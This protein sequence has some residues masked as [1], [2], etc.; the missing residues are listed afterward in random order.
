MSQGQLGLAGQAQAFGQAG[1]TFDRNYGVYQD[2]RDTA[3]NQQMG[4]AQLGQNSATNYGNQ[5]GGYY[6]GQGNANGAAAIQQGNAWS[7]A[8][9]GIGNAVAGAAGGFWGGGGVMAGQGDAIPW[10]NG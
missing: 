6:S 3:W 1:Q 8:V 5:A 7:G 4:L 10:S 9:G 2:N